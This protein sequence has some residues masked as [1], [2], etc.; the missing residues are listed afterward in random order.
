M[1]V[2]PVDAGPA[3]APSF[4]QPGVFALLHGWAH[5]NHAPEGS[6]PTEYGA[7]RPPDAMLEELARGMRHVRSIAGDRLLPVLVPPWNSIEAELVPQLKR[8]G[9]EAMST[10]GPR[11]AGAH[12]GVFEVNC[13]VDIVDWSVPP[14]PGPP[15][16]RFGFVGETLALSHLIGHLRARRT[17]T[18]DQAEPT[19]IMTHHF[20]HDDACFTFLEALLDRTTKRHGVT[21]L[22]AP[23]VFC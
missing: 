19:G 23:D 22:A 2:V 12:A 16:P 9:V 10:F 5:H 6:S 4:E 21:W 7:H 13:H 1:A 17:G 14:S 20:S 3:L 11:P 8:A 15:P 18:V